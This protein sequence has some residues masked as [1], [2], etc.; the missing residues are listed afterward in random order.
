[1]IIPSVRLPISPPYKGSRSL[2]FPGAIDRS[3]VITSPVASP[4]V[5]PGVGTRNE[6]FGVDILL[7]LPEP[8]TPGP[9]LL[10]FLLNFCGP[11]SGIERTN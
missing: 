3:C 9:D 2:S 6:I 1:M 7:Y 10:E 8:L 4:S 5:P 11:R